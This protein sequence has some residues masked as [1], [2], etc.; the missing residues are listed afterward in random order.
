M[1]L[2]KATTEQ[3]NAASPNERLRQAFHQN[4]QAREADG[5]YSGTADHMPLIRWVFVD[6]DGQTALNAGKLFLDLA[7]KLVNQP[8]WQ[9]DTHPTTKGKIIVDNEGKKHEYTALMLPVLHKTRTGFRWVEFKNNVRLPTLPW[10]SSQLAHTWLTLR[11]LLSQAVVCAS[12]CDLNLGDLGAAWCMTPSQTRAYLLS[13]NCVFTNVAD[14]PNGGKPED[15]ED[16]R[17]NTAEFGDLILHNILEVESEESSMTRVIVVTL[18]DAGALFQM[19][20]A[21][22]RAAT[23]CWHPRVSSISTDGQLPLSRSIRA[24]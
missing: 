8:S 5:L 24:C 18:G 15:L 22:P 17:Y 7:C 23:T 6:N 11:K 12:S 21:L 9:K 3:W 1:A 2:L 4:A 16:W 13:E 20:A 14:G 19:S 10:P